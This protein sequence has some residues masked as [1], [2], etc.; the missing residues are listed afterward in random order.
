MSTRDN[1]ERHFKR[2]GTKLAKL[3]ENCLTVTVRGSGG[4][5]PA[6]HVIISH[7]CCI[8]I[9]KESFKV[10]TFSK[11]RQSY[12]LTKPDKIHHRDEATVVATFSHCYII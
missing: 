2:R 3:D 10:T 12:V 5:N 1:N 6:S 8:H 4:G 7:L 11:L 9:M